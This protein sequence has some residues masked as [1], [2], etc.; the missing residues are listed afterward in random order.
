MKVLLSQQKIFT[1]AL[2]RE[3]IDKDQI[4]QLAEEARARETLAERWA[5]VKA[6]RRYRAEQLYTDI[7]ALLRAAGLETTKNGNFSRHVERGI[8]GLVMTVVARLKP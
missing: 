8:K 6:D 7:H 1:H 3:P 5:N 4:W 2:M